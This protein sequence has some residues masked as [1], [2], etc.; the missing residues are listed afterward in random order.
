MSFCMGNFLDKI[1]E[2]ILNNEL[3]TK[4]ER[5]LLSFSGGVDSSVLLDI[6]M[7]L[8]E[9]LNFE[10]CLFHLNHNIRPEAR[11]DQIFCE[12]KAKEYGLKIFSY[13]ER[14]LEF[15]SDNSLSIEEAARN[16]RYK[17]INNIVNENKIDKVVLGHNLDDNV[18]TFFLNL[19]R[20]SALKG[21]GGM[22]FKKGIFV[23]PLLG[24]AKSSIYKYANSSSVDY[25]EDST[26]QDNMYSRNKIRNIFIEQLKEEYGNDIIKRISG[27]MELLREDEKFFDDYICDNIELDKDFYFKDD[28]RKL[29]DV[30]LNRF[31]LKKVL[32]RKDVTFKQ[33]MSVNKFIRKSDSGRMSIGN[34]WIVNQQDK[35]F[36]LDKL[37]DKTEVLY[38]LKLGKNHSLGLEINYKISEEAVFDKNTISIPLNQIN[39]D[40]V[41]R[42]RRS[43]DKF[44]PYNMGGTKKVKDLLIDEKIPR[45]FRDEIPILADDIRIYWV[46]NIRKAHIKELKAPFV[47]ISIKED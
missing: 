37:P 36:F 35:V 32:S 10:L 9:S 40:L 4:D 24:T 8:K 12:K 21:L 38:K 39:G 20:G 45:I 46:Y 3:I 30:I 41:I 11:M 6:I 18:E 7:K 14:V 22:Q 44:L 43:G 23:R 17:I 25:V 5:V 34:I 2:I 47:V 28:L 16:I 19:F 13:S 42:N 27:T 15:A 31:L 33:V 26:N 29:D 1:T